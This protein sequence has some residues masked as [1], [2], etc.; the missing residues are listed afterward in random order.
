MYSI[1]VLLGSIFI[2]LIGVGVM[3]L[4]EFSS[5]GY[6]VCY[7]ITSTFFLLLAAAES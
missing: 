2:A 4:T 6:Y 1:D 3:I 7:T 5:C